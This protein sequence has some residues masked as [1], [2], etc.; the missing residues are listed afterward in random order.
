MSNK[1]IPNNNNKAR[2]QKS[3]KNMWIFILSLI[4]SFLLLAAIVINLP[5]FYRDG[6]FKLNLDSISPGRL[7][8]ILDKSQAYYYYPISDSLILKM[9]KTQSSILNLKAE[10]ELSLD[11]GFEQPILSE[12]GSYFV[13]T[14][15]N[16]PKYF[17]F[18]KKGL[19]Y[20]GKTN[21]SIISATVS[22]SGYL[23]LLLDNPDKRS[24]IKVF[25]NDGSELFDIN[26]QDEKISG[27]VVD[28][29][30]NH[31]NNQLLLSM[32]NVSSSSPFSIINVYSLNANNLGKLIA[33]Y[34][35]NDSSIIASL[36]MDE[37][38][39]LLAFASHKVLTLEDNNIKEKLKYASLF[40]GDISD[41]LAFIIAN[42]AESGPLYLK[43]W[44]SYY[45]EYEEFK[46]NDFHFPG[47]ISQF[48]YSG[49]YLVALIGKNLYKYDLRK[50]VDV[51]PYIFESPIIRFRV[52]KSGD[53]LVICENGVY[54]ILN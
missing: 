21:H 18:N 43:T 10:E 32:L 12:N 37:N 47:T 8:F 39:N 50:P 40:Y 14:E 23:A 3:S 16:S 29:K 20:Q 27:F 24:F 9:G 28:M 41:G 45:K 54:Q 13:L 42:Q 1:N 22:S 53:I 36:S 26:I 4:A 30:F 46:A 51:N 17:V 35:P 5:F 19:V 7:C 11:L 2:K 44:N 49:N 25:N 6:T 48:S 52:S 38:N 15:R 31:D 34:R 33:E